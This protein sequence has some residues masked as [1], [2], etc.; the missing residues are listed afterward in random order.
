M[1][2]G[3]DFKDKE[4]GNMNTVRAKMEKV[5]EQRKK[6]EGYRCSRKK[7]RRYSK[8]E[9]VEDPGNAGDV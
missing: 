8:T 5:R 9:N 4:A 2:E 7:S 6:K 1:V 3:I